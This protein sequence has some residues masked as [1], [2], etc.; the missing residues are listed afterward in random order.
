MLRNPWGREDWEADQTNLHISQR[1]KV[2]GKG[3]LSQVSSFST[4]LSVFPFCQQGG[5][6]TRGKP[7]HTREPLKGLRTEG[8][9]CI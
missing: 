1:W 5:K 9:R 7:V 3:S 8:T 4:L 2:D 6:P